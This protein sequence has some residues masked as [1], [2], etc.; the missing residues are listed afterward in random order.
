MK[1]VSHPVE[2]GLGVVVCVRVADSS[3]DG[4]E[5]ATSASAGGTSDGRGSRGDRGTR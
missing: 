1:M 5:G 4:D 3:A 2:S